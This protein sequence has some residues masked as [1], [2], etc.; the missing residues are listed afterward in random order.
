MRRILISA[1]IICLFCSVAFALD[2]VSELP[3]GQSTTVGK[4]RIIIHTGF[5]DNITKSPT[6]NE[7][8]KNYWEFI[9][10]INVGYEPAISAGI[11]MLSLFPKH[12]RFDDHY[13]LA[14]LARAISDK[15]EFWKI[16]R[17]KK[18]HVQINIIS[19]FDS[20]KS[21]YV[22]I[23]GYDYMKKEILLKIEHTDNK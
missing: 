4:D 1:L 8:T 6:I 3:F 15:D 20:N 11:D 13:G 7:W 23:E 9:Y 22:G 10:F 16:L 19:Y 12:N 2:N 21:D 5:I 17:N 18:K 14:T